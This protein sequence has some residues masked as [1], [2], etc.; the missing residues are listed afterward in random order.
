MPDRLSF[1]H[2]FHALVQAMGITQKRNSLIASNISN[3]D[4]PNY[5]SKDID[6]KAAMARALESTDNTH[7]KRTHPKHMDISTDNAADSDLFEEKGEWNGINWVDVDQAMVK[8]TENSLLYRVATET[9]LRKISLM[10]EVIKEGG[11]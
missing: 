1:Q 6:F 4:T 5:R 3:L 11:R 9:L 8:L 2:T 7:M 10:K